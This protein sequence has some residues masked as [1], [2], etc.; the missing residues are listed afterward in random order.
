MSFDRRKDEIDE[1]EVMEKNQESGVASINSLQ[2]SKSLVIGC[3]RQEDEQLGANILILPP[4]KR[5]CN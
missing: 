1:M 4:W 3:E 5:A 2:I